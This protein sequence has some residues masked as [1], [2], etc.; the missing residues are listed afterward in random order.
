MG[1]PSLKPEKSRTYEL[2]W[3]SQF[4]DD[5]VLETSLY[6]TDFRN[7]I[8][9][10]TDQATGLSTLE[11]ADRARIHGFEASLKQTL[12]GWQSDLGL[13]ILDPRNRENGHTLANRARRTLSWD[14]DRRF[15]SIGIGA[16]AKAVSSSY[17]NATN[18]QKLP[19][20]GLLDLRGSWQASQELAFD[21]TWSNVLDKGYSRA[22][23]SYAGQQHGYAEMPSTIM[24]GLTWTPS[25]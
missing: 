3:R 5:T 9:S 7:L 14:L 4:G 21:L 18:T 11:N 23:Y 17:A 22:Q 12:F 6:R 19:G 24:L 8:A 1:N 25:L 20:Y 15:G 10:T 2:Q 16:S 13:S